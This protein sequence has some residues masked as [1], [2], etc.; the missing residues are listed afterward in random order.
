MATAVLLAVFLCGCAQGTGAEVE[1]DLPDLVI[2]IDS[3]YEPYTYIDEQGN[4]AGLDVDVATELCQRLGWEPVFTPIKWDQKN[5]YLEEGSIDCIWS[6]FS[7]NGREEDYDWVGPYM[8]SR[9]VVAVRS[10]SNITELSQLTDQRMAVISSTKP[11]T[12][13]LERESE[14]IPAVKALY[15]METMDLVFSALQSGYVDGVA[16]HETVIGQYMSNVPG[17]YRMLDEELLS[18]DV[19]IAFEKGTHEETR[20]Q[21]TQTLSEMEADG[22]LAAILAEYGITDSG[23][24]GAQS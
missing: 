21:M 16:G 3:T 12:L 11:E 9:Q 15:C 22:T 6:C 8:H 18:A 14:N 13:L 5:Q 19:G 23:E 20:S 10:D 2:G 1:E 24:G 4:Y 7:M 17:Q